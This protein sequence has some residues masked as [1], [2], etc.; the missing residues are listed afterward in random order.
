[1]Y[2]EGECSLQVYV[3]GCMNAV[4]ASEEDTIANEVLDESQN[5][6]LGEV[7]LLALFHQS[8]SNREGNEQFSSWNLSPSLIILK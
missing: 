1:M 2:A 5:A 6:V 8:Y 4:G 3:G 7:G